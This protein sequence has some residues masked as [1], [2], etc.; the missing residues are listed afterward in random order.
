VIF[1]KKRS[2]FMEIN[3]GKTYSFFLKG[4]EVPDGSGFFEDK[5]MVLKILEKPVDEIKRKFFDHLLESSWFYVFNE[6]TKKKHFFMLSPEH[7][8]KEIN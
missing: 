2:N 1:Y 5:L 8:I 7:E 4:T 3:I 6:K